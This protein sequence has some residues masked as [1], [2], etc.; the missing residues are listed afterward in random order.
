MIAWLKKFFSGV[1]NVIA[2]V[3]VALGGILFGLWQMA[4]GKAKSE[5]A[6][7]DNAEARA[8]DSAASA[9]RERTLG[10]DVKRIEE[11]GRA[12]REKILTDAE[13]AEVEATRAQAAK[14]AELRAKEEERLRAV[15][16]AADAWDAEFL[17]TGSAAAEAK[18]RMLEDEAALEKKP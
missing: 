12:E 7:A 4:R 16:S 9:E 15:K 3:A 14:L 13:A 2:L 1:G 10:E 17:R 11:K 6:R 18:R 5:G 8:D